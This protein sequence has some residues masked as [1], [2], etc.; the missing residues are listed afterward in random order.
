MRSRFD[1]HKNGW[2]FPFVDIFWI[3]QNKTHVWVNTEKMTH[4]KSNIYPLTSRPFAG[5][6]LPA[7]RDPRK[8]LE[9]IYPHDVLSG[10][11]VLSGK[12]LLS[13]KCV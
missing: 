1:K 3:D 13:G 12:F 6:M 10:K 7:P 11:C 2:D 4:A 5:R 8:T 9:E